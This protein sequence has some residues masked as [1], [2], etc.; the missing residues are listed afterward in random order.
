MHRSR[1]YGKPHIAIAARQT[2]DGYSDTVYELHRKAA[3]IR[4][5]YTELFSRLQRN[6][7]DK[8]LPFWN[9]DGHTCCAYHKK[10]QY[11]KGEAV[12]FV[13]E[14]PNYR[15]PGAKKIF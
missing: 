12:P 10:T 3:Y 4:L 5:F 1:R 14:L 8:H 6:Y 7:N 15:M 9:T 11:L 2:N 13:M